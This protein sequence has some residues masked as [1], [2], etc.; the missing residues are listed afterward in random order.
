MGTC[1]WELDVA[2][3]AAGWQAVAAGL[4]REEEARFA[5]MQAGGAVYGTAGFRDRSAGLY[6]CCTL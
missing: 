2:N 5:A 6:V 4:V 1:V 3:M